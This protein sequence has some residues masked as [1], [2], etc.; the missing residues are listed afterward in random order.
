ML[1]MSRV[2]EWQTV[3]VAFACLSFCTRSAA[4]GFP[5]NISPPKHHHLRPSI[6]TPLRISNSCT[7]AGV[8]AT[9]PL[10][11]PSSNFPYS[12]DETHQ[13][14]SPEDRLINCRCESICRG[15]GACTKIPCTLPVGVQ[16]TGSPAA[17]PLRVVASGRT[18]VS[19]E[20]P[21]SCR[22][23]LHPHINLRS[24]ILPHPHKTSAPPRIPRRLKAATAA[25]SRNG[26]L[27][28][29]RDRR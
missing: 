5:D 25:P 3:T 15:I 21:A 7:P 24:G 1:P 9:N 29:S 22:P 23:L 16:L 4:I 13:H 18:F 14:L 19:D 6:F 12:A 17:T 2:C 28:R 26:F 20:S 10:V 27:R 8:H 11:S